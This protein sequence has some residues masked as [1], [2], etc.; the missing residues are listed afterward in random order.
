MADD[1]D[2]PWRG[3]VDKPFLEN[4]HEGLKEGRVKYWHGIKKFGYITPKDG[5]EEV[6]VWSGA[7]QDE[8]EPDISE[9]KPRTPVLYQ[10]KRNQQRN[11]LN[12]TICIVDRRSPLEKYAALQG[13]G[14]ITAP[15]NNDRVAPYPVVMQGVGDLQSITD[16][17]SSTVRVGPG[18]AAI[19]HPAPQNS[20]QFTEDFWAQYSAALANAWAEAGQGQSAATSTVR[21]TADSM[22]Q[23]TSSGSSSGAVSGTGLLSL[24]VAAPAKAL[25]PAPTA[26]APLAPAP[27]AKAE[28]GENKRSTWTCPD[29]EAEIGVAF[30]T[31]DFCSMM[32]PP[33]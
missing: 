20:G 24:E 4:P 25:A 3:K 6:F 31:C 26:K 13:G 28:A 16:T 32:G 15:K 30:D 17:N 9:L 12:A 14:K 7:I 8:L 29:C 21:I 23:N 1:D 11:S 10:A 22:A 33:K 27:T 5:S 18:N 2:R 19:P